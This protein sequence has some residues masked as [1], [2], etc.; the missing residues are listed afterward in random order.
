MAR[1][2]LQVERRKL[3]RNE[4]KMKERAEKDAR[5]RASQYRDPAPPRYPRAAFREEPAP[6]DPSWIPGSPVGRGRGR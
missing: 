1:S 6:I 2:D 3:R 5:R 4:R